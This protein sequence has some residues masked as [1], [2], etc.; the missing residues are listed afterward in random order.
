MTPKA[1]VLLHRNLV[2]NC[3]QN[4]AWI[5]RDGSTLEVFYAVLPFFHAFGLQVSLVLGIRIGATLVVFPKFEVAAV[6]AAQK[7]R[8]CTF[9]PAVPPMLERIEKAAAEQ[10]VDL[11]SITF[12]FSGAMPLPAHT[13]QQWENATGGYVIEG[14]GMTETSPIALGNPVSADRRPGALGLPYPSTEIRVVDAETL[15]DVEPGHRGELLIRGPQ[16]FAGYWN[17]PEETAHQ[18]LPDGFLRTGDVVVVGADGFV[19]LVDRIKE[20]IVTGGFKVY[21][22]QVEDHLREMPG[23]TDIAIVG[24]PPAT[25]A[26]RSSPQSFSTRPSRPSRSN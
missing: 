7:R 26:R 23:I 1:A 8:P 11:T 10:G 19:T 20:M 25:S 18:L 22:S 14:Y 13:A 2:A 24:L 4:Q 6:L 5:Q 12:A 16:V 21:P 15:A 17:R 9:L 3:V